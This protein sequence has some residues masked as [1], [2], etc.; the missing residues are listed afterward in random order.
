VTL[1]PAIH[2]ALVCRS[3]F[4]FPRELLPIYPPL[5]LGAAWAIDWFN[6]WSRRRESGE[7]RL[8]PFLLIGLCLVS[9][10]F[11]VRQTYEKQRRIVRGNTK[12]LAKQWAETHL[13]RAAK[14]VRDGSV[15]PMRDTHP[16]EIFVYALGY[17]PY[18]YYVEQGVHYLMKGRLPAGIDRSRPE[19]AARDREIERRG[20]LMAAWNSESLGLIG[21]DLAV[22][23]VVEN[24]SSCPGGLLEKP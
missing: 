19:V 23:R 18:C 12:V 14:I 17:H 3:S 1:H 4:G 6:S 2:Y 10:L 5:C 24:A 21:P 22:Y 11:P 13:P 7:I 16:Q 15:L 20:Q 9:L 8:T